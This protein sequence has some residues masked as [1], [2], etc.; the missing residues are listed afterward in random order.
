MKKPDAFAALSEPDRV[1][2]R[3]IADTFGKPDAICIRFSDGRRYDG[4]TFMSAQDYPDFRQRAD[5]LHQRFL[6]GQA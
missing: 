4:G 2:L 6:Q 5:V 1:F 3:A